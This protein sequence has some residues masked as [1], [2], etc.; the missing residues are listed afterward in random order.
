VQVKKWEVRKL[1]TLQH[2]HFYFH[3]LPR[4]TGSSEA[5]FLDQKQIKTK[6]KTLCPAIADNRC[7][8]WFLAPSPGQGEGWDGGRMLTIISVFIL[9][10]ARF[11]LFPFCSAQTGTRRAS[12]QSH[13]NDGCGI[14]TLPA[15]RQLNSRIR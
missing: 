15:T 12:L 6:V 1:A 2:L 5:E 3:F 7:D 13:R 14:K 4:T 10:A 8:A 11:G 9:T